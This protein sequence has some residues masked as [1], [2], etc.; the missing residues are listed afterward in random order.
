MKH[1][2]GRAPAVTF[3]AWFCV[4]VL[5]CGEETAEEG[6][7]G[8]EAPPVAAAESPVPPSAAESAAEPLP[9]TLEAVNESGVEGR[10]TK[11][12][13]DDSI[14][15]SLMVQGLPRDGE[16]AAHI[17]RGTCVSGGT[18]VV[19]LNPVRAESDGMGRSLTTIPAD[20]L[21]DDE[22]HFVQVRGSSGVLACGDVHGS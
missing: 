6:A 8:E 18:V 7:S 15:L 4:A 2:F 19:Q 12:E 20:R 21:P 9:V 22:P 5:A 16:Y 3:A 1:P 13:M 11:I 17:H 10:A 14:Q